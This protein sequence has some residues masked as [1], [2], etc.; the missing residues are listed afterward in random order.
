MSLPSR[1][2]LAAFLFV[3]VAVVPLPGRATTVD[4]GP[5][6]AVPLMVPAPEPDGL[7][8]LG[9][10]MYGWEP[11]GIVAGGSQLR[12]HT[13]GSDVWEVWV[14]QVG[15]GVGITPSEV[16]AVYDAQVATHFDW[17]SEGA[18]SLSFVPGGT[19]TATDVFDCENRASPSGTSNGAVFVADGL[20][21]FGLGGAGLMCPSGGSCLGISDLYPSNQRAVYVGAETV[22]G[23][24]FGP[25]PLVAVAAHEIGHAAGFPHSYTGVTSSQYD[26]P[27]DLMSGNLVGAS[28]SQS[29]TEPDPY[30]TIA[31][32]RYAAGWI[33]PGDV[34]VYDGTALDVDLGAVGSSG[35]EMI[36]F[37]TSTQGVMTVLGAR[38]SSPDDPFPASWEGVDVYRIDQTTAWCDPTWAQCFGANRRTI[39]EPADPFTVD[40][41]LGVGETVTVDGVQVTVVAAT[42]DGFRVTVA[43]TGSG[44]PAF[45]DISGTTFEGDIEWLA[46]AGITK[47]C[48]P[49]ANTLYCPNDPVTRGQMA[50]FLV[51]ALGLPAATKDH[52]V[53]D[54]GSTFEDDINRL[55]EAGITKGCNPPANTSYCPDDTVTR[56]QMAA[57]L[58]R[59]LG[60]TA[61]AG[62]DLF[63]DDDGSTFEDDI[64]RL[65][66]AGVTKGCNPP[67]NTLYCPSD[68]VTRGQMAAFLHRALG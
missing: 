46:A 35:V 5:E 13:L 52:F 24:L 55:A 47:G 59:A 38:R 61:G 33:D 4:P 12:R 28:G 1:R 20:L 36:V 39:P 7:R 2:L 14:C 44:S 57:F 54:D 23:G 3:S 8:P 65:A 62:A 53:D 25:D 26:N 41:H 11:L 48:N 43:G 63:A 45:A 37:P 56:G 60:Y 58:V 21:G 34:V 6:G 15:G 9:T 40:H 16:A 68:A 31:F 18:Y 51:R 30:A 64:D 32:N 42:A 22:R 10:D 67:T 50:A 27:V 66:T 19:V 17:L 29:S 49:P